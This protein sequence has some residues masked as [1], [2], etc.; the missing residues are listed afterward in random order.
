MHKK[1]IVSAALALERWCVRNTGKP[2]APRENYFLIH[3]WLNLQIL[4]LVAYGQQ[5][6]PLHAPELLVRRFG[7]VY[8]LLGHPKSSFR[9]PGGPP[10]V[11]LSK[12]SRWI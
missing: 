12:S 7:V 8:G 6:W 10:E 5:H 1:L 3:A 4:H 11:N 2:L 9:T